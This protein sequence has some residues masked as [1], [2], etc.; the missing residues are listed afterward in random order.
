MRWVTYLSPSGGGERVG[1]LDDGDVLGSPDHGDLAAL[2][3]SGGEQL[4]EA[5]ERAVHAP[6]EII[7]E[8]EARVCAPVRPTAPVPVRVDDGVLQVGPELVQGVD[9]AVPPDARAARI[10]V[11]A[12]AGADRPAAAYTPA[13]L[14]LDADAHPVQLSLGPVLTT[15]DEIS[16]TSLDL[17]ASVEDREPGRARLDP[18][19]EW[20]VSGPGPVRAVLPLT[21]LDLAAEDELFVDSDTLGTFEVRVGSQV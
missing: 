3:A 16:G 6:V 5:Y 1:A 20:L 18:A 9:D 13:C 10:G 11:A 8:L 15:A 21:A 17:S 19:H 2:L 12:V 14:W 7:V 4:T